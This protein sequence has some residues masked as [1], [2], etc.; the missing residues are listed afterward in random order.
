M[1]INNSINSSKMIDSEKK[2]SLSEVKFVEKNEIGNFKKKFSQENLSDEEVLK[3]KCFKIF[4]NFSKFSKDE[5]KFFLSHQALIKILKYINILTAK[6]LKLSDVDMILKKVC[7]GTKLNKDQFLDFIVQVSMKIDPKNFENFPKESTINV[8]K[9]FFEPFVLYIEK[10]NCSIDD[11]FAAQ[12]NLYLQQSIIT[13]LTKFEIDSKL[14]SLLN[15]L[16]TTL[17]EVFTV[18]FIYEMSNGKEDK[19]LKGSFTNYIEFNKDFEICPYLLNMN[20]IVCYWN[21]VN[22]LEHTNRNTAPI[23]DEKRDLG[24][25]FK[26][27]KFSLMIIHF[28][29]MTFGKINQSL[30]SQFSNIE[31]LLFFLEKLENALGF[32]NLERKTN[33]PHNSVVTFI[34]SKSLIRNVSC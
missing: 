12:S 31:K 17:R 20:Q 28:G 14:I 21:Y 4:D 1:I 16:Y 25:V 10:Q 26:L 11:P 29:L 7:N 33:K 15:S 24:K 19:I 32:K 23:F 22:D 8:M 9:T 18:Y 27:S 13:F 30:N 5:G 6:M 2:D 3:N 34:P